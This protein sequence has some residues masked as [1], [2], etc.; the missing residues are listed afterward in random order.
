MRARAARPVPAERA[1][2]GSVVLRLFLPITRE[3]DPCALSGTRDVERG[4][5]ESPGSLRRESKMVT[6]GKSAATLANR[7]GD[8]CGRSLSYL[9]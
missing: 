1:C 9:H 2:P 8:P 5:G 3:S 6:A 7:G 4:T